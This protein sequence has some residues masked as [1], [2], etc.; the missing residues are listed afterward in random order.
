MDPITAVGLASN[1]LQLVGL[2]CKVALTARDIY[3]SSTGLSSEIERYRSQAIEVQEELESFK[4]GITNDEKLRSLADSLLQQI[5][6]YVAYI[7]DLRNRRNSR[8]GALWAAGRTYFKTDELVLR[9]DSLREAGTGLSTH[10]I[11]VHLPRIDSRLAMMESKNEERESKLH[12][13]MG[14][15]V[16]QVEE[17]DGKN[18]VAQSILLVAV[19]RWLNEREIL[20]SRQAC[21][22]ALY[23]PESRRR[24]DML[25][26]YRGTFN[27]LL[28]D[29]ESSNRGHVQLLNWLK[30][31]DSSR[32]L[33]WLS[34]KP[35]SGKST[36]MKCIEHN[37][38][39]DEILRDWANGTP[40]LKAGYFFWKPRS[41]L[42]RSMK[43]LLRSCLYQA[44]LQHP[45]LLELV[46]P[47]QE[48]EWMIIGSQYDFSVAELH[49]AVGR[50]IAHCE[51]LQI[52]LFLLLN[53]LDE[54][55][56]RDKGG[57]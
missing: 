9:R 5:G 20:K 34:G 47:H 14:R 2:G 28:D 19:K 48:S 24:E 12:H 37:P 31:S 36:L 44:L 4:A 18:E 38:G 46:F 26:S 33:S 56:E 45:G 7:D 51:H 40:L 54:I 16:T 42:Q 49:S 27:W 30:S 10:I 23:Y 57:E 13:E 53:G 50:L 11:M 39:L 25:S 1:V 32:N 6:E 35:G 3:K 15:L 8:F 55:D 52:R 29:T 21:L 43:G 41:A 17:L 22:Q